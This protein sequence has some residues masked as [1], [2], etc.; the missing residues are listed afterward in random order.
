MCKIPSGARFIIAGKKGSDKQLTKH[1]TSA[2]K[3]FFSQR[4]AYHIKIYYYF[5][6][7][8]T[9][10]AI[11]GKSLLLECINKINKRKSGKQISTFNFSTLYTKKPH[12]KLH[13]ILYK[14]V[15]FVFKGGTR[16]SI[17]INKHNCAS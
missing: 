4:D 14:V 5:S 11:Q 15:D 17:T 6:G 16:D 12:D 9:F 8:N 1:V 7:A 3:L 13:D 10:W 2:F